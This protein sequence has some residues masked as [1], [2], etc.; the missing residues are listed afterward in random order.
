MEVVM[1]YV[2]VLFKNVPGENANNN[3]RRSSLDGLLAKTSKL[4][5]PRYEAVVKMAVFWVYAP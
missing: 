3:M 2:K 1:A 5:S 4:V